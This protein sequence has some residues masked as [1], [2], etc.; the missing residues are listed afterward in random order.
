M[1]LTRQMVSFTFHISFCC[2]LNVGRQMGWSRL[3]GHGCQSDGSDGMGTSIGHGLQMGWMV[4]M[5]WAQP[6]GTHADG[7]DWMGTVR[8][9]GANTTSGVTASCYRTARTQALRQAVT[10]IGVTASCSDGSDDMGT[11]LGTVAD[12][13]PFVQKKLF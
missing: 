5:V 1:F 9:H 2:G 3:D 4:Q 12:G 11:T 8:G 13:M 10:T 7:S 6:F